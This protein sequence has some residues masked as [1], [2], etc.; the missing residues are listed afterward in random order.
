M[1]ESMQILILR[2][3]QSKYNNLLFSM[4]FSKTFNCLYPWNQLVHNFNV[5]VMYSK[6]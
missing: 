5:V 2:Y 1:S 4:L 3:G 6:V